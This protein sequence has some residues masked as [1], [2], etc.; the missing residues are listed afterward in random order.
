M[1][2]RVSV[3]V[4]SEVGQVRSFNWRDTKW[5]EEEEVDK[6]VG[7]GVQPVK[8]SCLDRESHNRERIAV[9]WPGYVAKKKRTMIAQGCFVIR[10]YGN[11]AVS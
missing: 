4:S 5:E 10:L 1:L 2:L 9:E 6:R 8:A 7:N 3:L 11:S